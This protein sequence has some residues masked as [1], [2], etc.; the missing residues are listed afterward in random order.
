[1]GLDQFGVKGG[2]PKKEK[3]K[4]KK[5]SKKSKSATP[6]ERKKFFLKCVKKCGFQRVLRKRALKDDDYEC[7]KCG[8]TLKLKKTE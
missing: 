8:R 6:G 7:P 4:P 2:K 3:K 1:M 5:N